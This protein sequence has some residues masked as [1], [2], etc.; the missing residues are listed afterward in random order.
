MYAR[1]V[2]SEKP[3]I[4]PYIMKFEWNGTIWSNTALV[5][6]TNEVGLSAK[7]WGIDADPWRRRVYVTLLPTT[8]G[9]S[10]V[11]VYDMDLTRIENHMPWNYAAQPTGVAVDN[12]NGTLLI[13]EAASNMIYKYTRDLD[14]VLAFGETG[15]QPYQFNKPTD[16]DVDM[17]GWLY[18]GDAGNS[19]IQVFAPPKEGNLNFLVYKSKVKV[20]WKQKLKGKDRDI[21]LC[22]AWAALDPYTNITSMIGMPFSFWC[23]EL[24]VISEMLPT[25]TNK[26]GNKALY[27][28]DKNHKAKVQ[29]RTQGALLKM[30][31]KLKRGAVD[32]PLG[33]TD[34]TPLPPWLWVR[35]QMTLTNE[36]LGVHYMRLEHKNKVGKVYKAWKK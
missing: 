17:H 12:R 35:A 31:V 34:T 10:G 19:R 14:P 15:N 30:T 2:I 27:K 8:N 9:T 6:V 36:F 21:I 13:T 11:K 1:L 18:V 5:V 32:G 28:P 23:N 22:K 26:K 24:P 20:G 3:F 7:P 29:Y 16:L 25:K 33:I 4:V